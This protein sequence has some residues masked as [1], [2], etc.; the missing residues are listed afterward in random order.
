MLGCS[1]SKSQIRAEMHVFAGDAAEV[2]PG[3]AQRRLDPGRVL[4]G[5]GGAQVGLADAVRRQ[6]ARAP[7]RGAAEIRRAVRVGAAQQSRSVLDQPPEDAVAVERQS[8]A[9]RAIRFDQQLA[10]HVAVLQPLQRRRGNQS[11]GNTVSITGVTPAAM[12]SSARASGRQRR[13]ERCR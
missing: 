11:S 9:H 7:R 6:T 2:L 5:E 8:P 1:G 10:E 12:R 3:A 13:A 4:V